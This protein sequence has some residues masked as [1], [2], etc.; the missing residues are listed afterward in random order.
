MNSQLRFT[1][2]W[3]AICQTYVHLTLKKTAY[4]GD[5]LQLEKVYF[6]LINPN[7]IG[8]KYSSVLLWWGEISHV[9]ILNYIYWSTDFFFFETRICHD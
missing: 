4:K 6:V 2:K 1:Q 3:H 7:H 8:V 5:Q 9:F